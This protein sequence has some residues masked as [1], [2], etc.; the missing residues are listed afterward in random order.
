VRQAEEQARADLAAANEAHEKAQAALQS[1]VAALERENAK[2]V[3]NLRQVRRHSR[4]WIHIERAGSWYE[5][6]EPDAYGVSEVDGSWSRDG[7][8]SL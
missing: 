7:L 6:F 1:K 5:Y 3:V 2:N 8:R 4:S